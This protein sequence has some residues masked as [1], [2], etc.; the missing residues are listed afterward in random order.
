MR[1]KR[2]F[3]WLVAGIALALLAGRAV[4]A[5]YADWAFHRAHGAG[6]LWRAEFVTGG[7]ARLAAFVVAFGFTFANLFAVRQ[8]IVSLVLPRRLGNIDF[9]ESVPPAR[10]TTLALG[11]ALVVGL[12]FAALGHD[13]TTVALAFGGAPFAEIEPFSGRD[14]GFFVHWVPFERALNSVA[15]LLVALNA[16]VVMVVY[17]VTPSVRWDERGLYVSTWVR[18]H[19]AILGGL[20]IALVGWDWRLDRFGLLTDGS[21]WA[22]L[23]EQGAFSHFDHQILTPY[24]VVLSFL[25][26]PTAVVFAWAVWR[27]YVRLALGLV[28]L[29]V[30]AGPVTRFTL[31]AVLKPSARDDA[32]TGRERPYEATRI[33][34]TRR[35]YG[36]DQVV[37]ATGSAMT[38]AQMA[39]WVSSWDPAALT[40]YLELERR[41]TDVAAFAWD[42]GPAGLEAVLLRGAPVDAPPGARWPADRLSARA[43]DALGLPVAIPGATSSGIGGILV[44]PGAPRYALVADTTGRLVA[45]PFETTL[46]RV[47]QAWD[48]QNPRL[49]AVDPPTP[50]ARLVTHRDV[51]TRV[52]KLAP[53]FRAGPTVTPLVRADALYWVVELFSVAQDYPLS[54]SHDF[55]GQRAHYVRHA[56]TAVVQAQTGAVMLLPAPVLDSL[57]GSWVRRFPELFTPRSAAPRWLASALPPPVDVALVQGTMATRTGFAGDTTPLVSLARVDDADA[58]LLAG[59]PTLMQLDSAGTLGWSLPVEGQSLRGTLTSRG[60]L[61]PR[62]E[63]VAHSLTIGW[64]EAL[65][66]L[67]AAADTAGF[68]RALAHSRRGRVQTVPTAAGTVFTQ[69]FYEWPPD[70]PPRLAGVVALTN[71]RTTVGRTLAEALGQRQ[72]SPERGLPVEVFRARVAALYDAMAAALRAGDWRAYGEAWAALGRLLGRP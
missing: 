28:T 20:V 69:S 11:G 54:L 71:G 24:L 63:F 58:D 33:L 21:G 47:L 67:L 3:L 5:L 44:E 53:F 57:S 1:G 9:G 62:T 7:L 4:A 72:A 59:P 17:W 52:R 8:S 22:R 25:A 45:P 66:Q 27:G 15:T 13:W 65:E 50:R 23:G 18:R 56:A 40:R 60:G 6:A 39:G 61:A 35:A 19:L 41:G 31:P 55:A 68:G 14:L 32:R 10:L 26:V 2:G 16:I 12:L 29:L 64:T 46:D 48:Q 38:P 30:V 42:A 51:F 34:Y 43:A 36:V 49:L 37:R 70:G